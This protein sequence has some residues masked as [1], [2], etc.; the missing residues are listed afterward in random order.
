MI[1]ERVSCQ[2][3]PLNDHSACLEITS[4]G[5]SVDVHELPLL[6]A[7]TPCIH[8]HLCLCTG[9]RNMIYSDRHDHRT[10]PVLPC[11][12]GTFAIYSLFCRFAKINPI[13]NVVPSDRT[14]RRYSTSQR[15][16]TAMTKGCAHPFMPLKASAW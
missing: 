4:G 12:G 13:G 9:A 1:M 16:L 15:R 2:L 3:C 5:I 10:S 14:L 11:A 6:K 7:A 8:S